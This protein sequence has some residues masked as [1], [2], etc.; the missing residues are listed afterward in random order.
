MEEPNPI[1]ISDFIWAEMA[2]LAEF[3]KEQ[4]IELEKIENEPVPWFLFGLNLGLFG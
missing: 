2:E 1:G 4:N 3:Q